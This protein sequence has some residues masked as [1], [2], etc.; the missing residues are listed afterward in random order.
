MR[1]FLPFVLAFFA[2]SPAAA[3]DCAEARRCKDFT[4]CKAAEAYFARCPRPE[5]DRDGDGHPC[6]TL[7][8]FNSRR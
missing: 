6:E 2:A 1:R 5:L 7:C 3:F 8:R 4:T